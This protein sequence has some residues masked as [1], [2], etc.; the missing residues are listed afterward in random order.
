MLQPAEIFLDRSGEEIR[1]RTFASPIR[2]ATN[3]AC[4]PI[5]PFRSAKCMSSDGGK[6]PARLCYNGLAF[7]H[8]P[9]EP[10]R[11]TQFYQAGVELLGVEDRA[12][13]ETEILTLAVEARAR[14]GPRAISR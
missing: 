13:A 11:P 2:R 1:R 6:F 5:S 10:E 9:A 4:A 12:A 7:R 8:Q 14:R 3:C